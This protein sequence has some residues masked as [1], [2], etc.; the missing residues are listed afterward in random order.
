MSTSESA[1]TYSYPAA[2]PRRLPEVEVR[3]EAGTTY[4]VDSRDRFVPTR[5]RWAFTE[6]SHVVTH[7]VSGTS[8]HGTVNDACCVWHLDDVVEDMVRKCTQWAEEAQAGAGDQSAAERHHADV[9]GSD[10]SATLCGLLYSEVNG[11]TGTDTDILRSLTGEALTDL[12][13]HYQTSGRRCP[14]CTEVAHAA[15]LGEI[16]R[17]PAP[18]DSDAE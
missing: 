13:G 4:A 11:A 2:A 6:C 8:G 9:D 12:L 1:I 10:A 7:I 16:E 15:V 3:V 17:R 18:T 5:C 14:T